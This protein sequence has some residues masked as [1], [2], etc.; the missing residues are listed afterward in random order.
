MSLLRTPLTSEELRRRSAVLA[1]EASNING[2]AV[3]DLEGSASLADALG[4]DNA[5]P[6]TRTA[7]QENGYRLLRRA[8][9]SW[10]R[11]LQG[12]AEEDRLEV[13]Q[14]AL[15]EMVPVAE[16]AAAVSE[17]FDWTTNYG[18]IFGLDTDAV[19]RALAKAREPRRALG[20]TNSNSDRLRPLDLRSFLQL[21][22]KT[23]EMLLD[24]V[25]PEKGL[26]MLYAARGTGKTHVA[27]G[28]V[29]AVATGSDFLKWCAPRPRRTLLIDGEMPA[30]AL[31]ERLASIVAGSPT[32]I[33]DPLNIKIIAGDLVEGAGIGNLASPEVQAELDQWLDDIDLLVLDNLS[34]LTAVIRDND[35]ESW[36]PIQEWLL[37][38]RR[39]GISVLIVH[40][41]G[42]G[43]Q[44]RGTSRREDVLDTSI[45]LRRP[46]DYSPEEGA[47]FEVHLEKARGV[48]GDAARPFE[49]KLETRDGTA[50]WTTRELEDANRARVEA[51]LEDGLSV[52]EIADE[53]GIPKSTVHRIKKALA[54][55]GVSDDE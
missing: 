8:F 55:S 32:V 25:L 12:A 33:F 40:H 19:Q 44:Q 1:Q 4:S 14:N 49:A 13:L 37:R 18:A 51:L 21:S 29:F 11:T 22:I 34:S 20:K 43:G 2:H 42:K 36:G 31:Q 26:A 10:E 6:E 45:S 16:L 38:L 30:A 3:A 27:L 7:D 39:R 15:R 47:K 28:I 48:H 53:T 23:R 46:A 50:V 5:S 35:S 24:P 52:R 41:A 17:L 9:L 54:R